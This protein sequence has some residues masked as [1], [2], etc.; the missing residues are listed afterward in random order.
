[1]IANLV[2]SKTLRNRQLGPSPLINGLGAVV[3]KRNAPRWK[4]RS[5][6]EE[7]LDSQL[8]FYNDR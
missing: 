5:G 2:S 6:V 7:R 4:G 8:Y 1:M 3:R